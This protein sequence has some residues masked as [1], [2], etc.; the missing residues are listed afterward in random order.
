M[1]IYGTYRKMTAELLHMALR[2]NAA[3]KLARE[4][5][6]AVVT[7]KYWLY[8]NIPVYRLKEVLAFAKQELLR[9]REEQGRLLEALNAQLSQLTGHSNEQAASNSLGTLGDLG[10]SP[11]GDGAPLHGRGDDVVERCG[12]VIREGVGDAGKDR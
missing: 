1:A 8:V 3:K 11:A 6:V 5:G 10:A 12:L 2:E 7:A 9:Q 4:F